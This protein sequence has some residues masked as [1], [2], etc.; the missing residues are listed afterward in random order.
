[1]SLATD[2]GI[3]RLLEL[4]D[5]DTDYVAIGSGAVPV[6]GST[7]LTTEEERKASTNTIDGNSITLEGFWDTDEGNGVTYSEAGAFG[8]GATASA[9][10]GTLLAGGAISVTKNNTQSLT[11]SV[12]ITIN[13]A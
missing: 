12:E 11:V 1:M 9:D 3:T 2:A 7:T 4:I 13:N 5:T 10:S 6:A 8:D